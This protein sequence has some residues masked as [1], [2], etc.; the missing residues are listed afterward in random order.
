M[1]Q[2]VQFYLNALHSLVNTIDEENNSTCDANIA[3]LKIIFLESGRLDGL[4]VEFMYMCVSVCCWCCICCFFLIGAA[5]FDLR[6]YNPLF[7]DQIHVHRRR[8]CHRTP[9]HPNGSSWPNLRLPCTL[10]PV[11]Q[12]TKSLVSKTVITKNSFVINLA[13]VLSVSQLGFNFGV[14]MK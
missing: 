7:N 11:K 3:N 4:E 2:K 10:Q 1:P 5:R 6:C 12:R 13:K 8:L 14:N 9:K